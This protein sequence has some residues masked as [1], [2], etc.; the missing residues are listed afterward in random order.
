[1]GKVHNLSFFRPQKHRT[2]LN[3]C[4]KCSS[5]RK[6]GKLQI[7][8]LSEPKLFFLFAQLAQFHFPCWMNDGNYLKTAYEPKNSILTCTISIPSQTKRGNLSSK[9]LNLNFFSPY[10]HN[11]VSQVKILF[12]FFP[13]F[14]AAAAA[15]AEGAAGRRRFTLPP[16][17][18][19][20][21]LYRGKR[22]LLDFRKKG[23]NLF[24]W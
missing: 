18:D 15:E 2:R 24:A 16:F 5:Q 1:M 6:R 17:G 13:C 10:W 7:K 14:R 3:H 22:R 4:Q 19:S 8:T 9:D 21:R 23:A 12:S 11:F 20:L